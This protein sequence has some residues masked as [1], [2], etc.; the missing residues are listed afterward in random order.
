MGLSRKK[1]T[2]RTKRG[3]T[4]Q[5]SVMVK[6]ESVSILRRH[7]KTAAISGFAG[8]ALSGVTGTAAG[9]AS[10][11]HAHRSKWNT[12]MWRS[13]KSSEA[14]MMR[15]GGVGLVGLLGGSAV[16]A[17]VSAAVRRQSKQWQSMRADMRAHPW[18]GGAVALR[19][20]HAGSSA[21][22]WTAGVVGSYKAGL[23]ALG[24]RKA[25][26]RGKTEGPVESEFIDLARRR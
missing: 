7:I 25:S 12:E 23:A 19:A 5:R 21:L 15:S 17:G 16:G 22:G 3:K 2:V 26:R 14:H 1:I 13:D 9:L 24:A 18:S 6:S 11:I 20:I 10:M 4:F 8:G